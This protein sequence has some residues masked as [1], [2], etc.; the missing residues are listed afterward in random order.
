MTGSRPPADSPP[1]EPPQPDVNFALQAAQVGTWDFDVANQQVWWDE[2]CKEL[3]GFE[4]DDRV[5]YQQ[6]LSYMHP[7]DRA[8]VDEAVQWVLNPQS[9]GNYDCQFRTLGASDGRL[10]WLHCRGRAFFNQQGVA[11]RF[12]GIAQDV[13]PLIQMRQQLDH[14][15]ARFTDLVMTTPVATVIFIGREMLIQQVNNPMLAIWGKEPSVI[16]KTLHQAMPELQGQPFLAQLQHV[17]D[18]G[19]PFRQLEG[20]TD[21]I[22]NGHRKRVWF[23]QACNPLYDQVGQIYGIINVVIDVTA[24]V[25]A[26]QKVEASEAHL[27]LLRDTVPAMIF[28]LD[29]DQRYQSYNKVFREWFAVGDEVQGQTVREFIGEPAYQATW[30]HLAKAYGGLQVQYEMLAPNR[31]SSHRWLSIVYTPHLNPQGRVIGVIVHAT[32]ITQ[33]KLME[34]QL[35]ESEAR[36]RLLSADLEQQVQRRTEELANANQELA[37]SNQEYVLVNTQLAGANTNLIRSNQ[38]LE[39]FAYIASHDLQEPLRKIQ[40]FS[41]LL[42]TRLADSVSGEDL[43]YLERMQLAARGMSHLIKDLLGFSRIA[44]SQAV[45]YPVSLDE[46]V[47]LA[48]DNLSVSIEES[49]AQIRVDTLP[50]VEGDK[51]QLSQ[52]FQNLLSNALKFRRIS[53]S[54]EVIIPQISLKA[55]VVKSGDLSTSLLPSLSAQTYHLIEVADN[56]IGFEEKY[57]DRIFQVFQRLHGKNEFA[58]TGV[59]LAIVQKVVT[60]HGGA[61]TASSKLGAGATFCVY[62]PA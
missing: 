42:K 34:L 61:I 44:T 50:I 60:N 16:G 52:L 1:N 43:V 15:Q 48:L 58:G 22:E 41:D 6:V 38:N 46:V 13:T 14:S 9:G 23:D 56:G 31:M 5:P 2:R 8:R 59:G 53:S 7:D 3:Y 55:K 47:R 33:R 49:G 24:Q 45:A 54:G 36:Y 37:V 39:Q 27:Q 12:A 26:R 32:D 20:V 57:L 21:L 18:T 19:E 25:L 10:R 11:Y 4:P 29:T 40:Q 51:M 28:Y 62:L 35:G 30:P 17:F